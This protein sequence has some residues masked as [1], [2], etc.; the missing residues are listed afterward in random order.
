M[1]NKAEIGG[2]A[3][4]GPDFDYCMQKPDGVM[5]SDKG[6]AMN[7]V[8][9]I[10]G[11]LV[12]GK[13]HILSVWNNSLRQRH[14][15]RA[16]MSRAPSHQ[17]L[18]GMQPAP[19]LSPVQDVANLK[20]PLFMAILQKQPG[21]ILGCGRLTSTLNRRGGGWTR[22]PKCHLPPKAYS[23]RHPTSE[24]SGARQRPTPTS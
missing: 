21:E 4:T 14:Q 16:V 11:A 2:V 12:V 20:L 23:H 18:P 7:R 5:D 3:P 19:I 17:N 9:F 8:Q 15:E 6:L 24:Q 22:L 13:E 10:Q 1:G